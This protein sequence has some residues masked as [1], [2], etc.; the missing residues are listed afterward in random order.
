MIDANSKTARTIATA[1]VLV[2]ASVHSC[3]N[4]RFGWNLGSHDFERYL[5]A[6]FGVAVD[7]CKVFA[8]A[9]AAHAWERRR[10][11]KAVCCVVVWATAVVYSGVAALGFAALARDTVV[12]SRSSSVDDYRHNTAEQKRLTA[13]MEAGR[14]SPIFGETYGCTDYNKAATKGADRK[15]AEFCHLYWRA[16][17]SL[18]EIKPQIRS[19][20]LT[21]ADPQI[22]I[23]ARISGYPRETI[24]TALAIFLAG[25]AEVVSALGTWTF[26][27]SFR[28]PVRNEAAHDQ[29]ARPKLVVSN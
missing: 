14:A 28:K 23:M 20:T 4:A 21:D 18:D 19:A 5:F 22:A 27:K 2:A 13:Q 24:A 9:F 3:M 12:A 7:I 29:L 15:K 8:L 26:S 11:A 17:A 16:A 1:A 10:K 6:A 25:V